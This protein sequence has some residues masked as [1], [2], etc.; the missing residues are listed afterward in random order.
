MKRAAL[1][2][3]GLVAAV[4]LV[5]CSSITADP[6]APTEDGF[7]ELDY[8]LVDEVKLP[9]GRTVVCIWGDAYNAGGLSCDWVSAG[10]PE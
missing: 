6:N 5:G 9:D 7:D 1:V 8:V 2:L 3:V 10:A 4:I